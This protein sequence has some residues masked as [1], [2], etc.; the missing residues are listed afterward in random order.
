LVETCSNSG[1]EILFARAE[2]L[3]AE[4]FRSGFKKRF[5]DNRFFDLRAD[6]LKYVWQELENSE[7]EDNQTQAEDLND[8]V[9]SN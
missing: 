5:G 2:R 3:E 1:I 7:N 6:A 9:A 4:L 8:A